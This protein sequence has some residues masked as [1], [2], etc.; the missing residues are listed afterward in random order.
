MREE[1]GIVLERPVA[2]EHLPPNHLQRQ[3]ADDV[4]QGRFLQPPEVHAGGS[5]DGLCD[6]PGKQLLLK[7]GVNVRAHCCA[8]RGSAGV[9]YTVRTYACTRTI[10][11][12]A[13]GWRACIFDEDVS[14]SQN[15]TVPYIIGPS[16]H[17]LPRA[18]KHSSS[19]CPEL[20]SET[21]PPGVGHLNR[22]TA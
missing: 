17:L 5:D 1:R 4:P 15:Q 3:E 13:P 22:E 20:L 11:G 9:C 14:L 18:G 21:H 6:L 19:I 10:A 12:H 16:T 7:W 8:L 2:L